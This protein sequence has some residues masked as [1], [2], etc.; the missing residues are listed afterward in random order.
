MTDEEST[1]LNRDEWDE[2]DEWDKGE[3]KIGI[4]IL[5][6]HSSLFIF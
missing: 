3:E 6:F 4:S 5:P 2:W 1:A